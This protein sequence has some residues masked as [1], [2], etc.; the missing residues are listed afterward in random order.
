MVGRKRSK[1]RRRKKINTE[2]EKDI[3]IILVKC[4]DLVLIITQTKSIP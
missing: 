3:A 4:V 1:G 2:V